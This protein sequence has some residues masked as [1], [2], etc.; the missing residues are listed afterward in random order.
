MTWTIAA[1]LLMTAPVATAAHKTVNTPKWGVNASL[2]FPSNRT[3]AGVFGA[4]W[5]GLGIGYGSVLER[6]DYKIQPDISVFSVK[7]SSTF[8]TTSDNKALLVNFGGQIRHAFSDPVVKGEVQPYCP[9][10]GIGFGGTYGDIKV[11]GT[12]NIASKGFRLNGSVFVGSSFGKTGSLELRYRWMP[13]Y[14]G[15][16]F[17]GASLALGIR[18]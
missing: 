14:G 13:S 6:T 7:R 1:A 5:F 8:S 3:T 18:F 10:A 11:P 16:D 15:F 17:K 9:Y 4:Q 2:F 12:T